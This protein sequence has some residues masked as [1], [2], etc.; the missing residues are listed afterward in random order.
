MKSYLIPSL[1]ENQ[2]RLLQDAAVTFYV[3]DQAKQSYIVVGDHLNRAL[4]LLKCNAEESPSP[5]EN[6]IQLTL[7]IRPPEVEQFVQVAGTSITIKTNG[8]PPPKTE[9][10]TLIDQVLGSVVGRKIIVHLPPKSAKAKHH[11]A[12]VED[13]CFHIHVWS[14]PTGKRSLATPKQIWGIALNCAS[15]SFALT[16]QG[17]PLMDEES[18]YAVAELLQQNLYIHHDLFGASADDGYQLLEALVH[19]VAPDINL[20]QAER[21]KAIKTR[22]SQ[23]RFKSRQQYIQACRSR[24]VVLIDA[25]RAS[26]RKTIAP[27]T[28]LQEQLLSLLRLDSFAGKTVTSEQHR[29]QF[30]AEFDRLR[31]VRGVKNVTVAGNLVM[32]NTDILCAQ[33]P[34]SGASHEIGKFLV[35]INLHGGKSPV[36]WLNGT[37]R[38][39]GL[40]PAMNA[41]GVYSDGTPIFDE[42]QETMLELIAR[43]E[44]S[45]VAELA[46]QFIE[47]V[48]S[49]LSGTHLAKWPLVQNSVASTSII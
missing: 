13:D 32:L 48:T 43:L 44:L 23:G 21:I 2:V 20:G 18:E 24:L 1:T 31:D 29:L 16:G 33:H 9:C 39:D 3:F 34:Q 38:V 35:V 15:K 7:T 28:G 4:D 12:P 30:A 22:H 36:R 5:F 6:V 46:I 17:I 8:T 11:R 49:D 41:P 26:F 10:I 47:S 27:L 42:I 40:R 14:S 25:A 19:K 37:R 45:I